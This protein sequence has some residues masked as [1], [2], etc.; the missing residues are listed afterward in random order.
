MII[1]NELVLNEYREE[2]RE[3]IRTVYSDYLVRQALLDRGYTA[4][5]IDTL[6][7]P[8]KVVD[9]PYN[10]SQVMRLYLKTKV[11]DTEKTTHFKKL[12]LEIHKH[13]LD[14]HKY[15][16]ATNVLKVQEIKEAKHIK[17]CK[18]RENKRRRLKVALNNKKDKI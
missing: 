4:S 3:F 14:V 15:I 6:Y 5:L 2:I 10:R 18:N 12:W 8:D 13:T 11:F 9:N 1:S 16:K 7:Q 17:K